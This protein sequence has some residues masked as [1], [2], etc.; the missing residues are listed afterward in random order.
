V[1]LIFLNFEFN[2]Q[3]FS[4]FQFIIFAALFAVATAAYGTTYSES[5]SFEIASSEGASSAPVYS[6]S[7]KHV[8]ISRIPRQTFSMI[9]TFSDCLSVRWQQ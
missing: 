1:I 8:R 2:S 4:T 3:I 5:A 7:G 6:A 9:F